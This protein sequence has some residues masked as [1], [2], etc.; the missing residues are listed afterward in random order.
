MSLMMKL[1]ERKQVRIRYG[2]QTKI[3]PLAGGLLRPTRAIPRLKTKHVWGCG[4]HAQTHTKLTA[5]T[6]CQLRSFAETADGHAMIK[7]NQ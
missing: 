4:H 1:N 3:A 2:V 5:V 7:P 6:I